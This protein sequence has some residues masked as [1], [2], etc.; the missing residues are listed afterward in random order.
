M[1]PESIIGFAIGLAV[2]A[3]LVR[4]RKKRAIEDAHHAK[5]EAE[6]VLSRAKQEFKR[7]KAGLDHHLDRILADQN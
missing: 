7:Y 1:S 2:G 4:L 3:F 6:I 5:L